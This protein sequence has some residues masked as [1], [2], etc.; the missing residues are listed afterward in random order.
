MPSASFFLFA[1][2]ETTSNLIGNGMLCLFRHP[3]QLALLR[4]QPSL[5]VGFI[6]ETL[7]YESP[8]QYTFRMARRDFDLFDQS[9]KKGQVLVFLSGAANRDP[10]VFEASNMFDIT[11]KK[12]AHLTFGYGLHHCIGAATARLEADIA[13]STLLRRTHNMQLLIDEP[14]WRDVFRFRG[15]RSLPVQF[16]VK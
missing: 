10:D 4:G 15:V 3:D 12:N 7:R 5:M 16:E 2:Y 11:R 14:Q 9:V 8:M 1:G 13:F 6:E